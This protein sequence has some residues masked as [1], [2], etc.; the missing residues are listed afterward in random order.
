VVVADRAAAEA[1]A[2]L[3]PG[4]DVVRLPFASLI[5]ESAKA[6]RRRTHVSDAARNVAYRD[7]R[8]IDLLAQL[9]EVD[10]CETKLP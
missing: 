1:L 4:A 7:R 6:G 2:E 10:E 5:P 9:D 3:Y 8:K